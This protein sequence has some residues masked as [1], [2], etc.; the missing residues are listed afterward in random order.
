MVNSILLDST[1]INVADS[2]VNNIIPL[3]LEGSHNDPPDTNPSFSKI[4][5]YSVPNYPAI[6]EE[7]KIQLIDFQLLPN[8]NRSNEISTFTPKNKKNI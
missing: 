6:T 4:W 3:I 8:G 2:I 7:E 5:R 1:E